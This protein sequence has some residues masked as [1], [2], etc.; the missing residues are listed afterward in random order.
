MDH[1]RDSERWIW[2]F[3]LLEKIGEGGMGVVYRASHATLRRPTA[4]KLLAAGRQDSDALTRFEREARLTASLTHPNTVA[5]FDYGRA[6]DGTFYY[7]MELLDGVDLHQL[8]RRYGPQ[9]QGRVVH[10]LTQLCASLAEAHALGHTHRDIKPSNVILCHRGG[11]PDVAKV[12]DFGL[13]TALDTAEPTVSHAGHFIGTPLFAAPEASEGAD[14]VTA[15]ADLYGVGCVGWFLLCGEPPF[16]AESAAAIC[17]LHVSAR[18]VP[19]SVRGVNVSPALESLILQCMA[20]R[21]DE[22][23]ASAR[24]L[25]RALQACPA[26]DWTMD[27]AAAWWEAHRAGAAQSPENEAPGD[28]ASAGAT[29]ATGSA[30]TG[31]TA[32]RSTATG[33]AATESPATG[34]TPTGSTPTG[35]T[36]TG[37]TATAPDH[38]DRHVDGAGMTVPGRRPR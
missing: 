17:A 25:R 28:R 24:E 13:A 30:T 10:I 21:P 2:P 19:P 15:P 29:R 16:L 5:V 7:A 20:K 33:A 14:A 34:S 12:V 23:P 22:R 8:V 37:R 32:A 4:V 35:S 11:D 38:A 27:M 3:E 1:T 31:G 6:E 36:P 9:P 26:D 18:P